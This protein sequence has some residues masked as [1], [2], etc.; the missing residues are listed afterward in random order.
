[1]NIKYWRQS[2]GKLYL[3]LV[4]LGH[5]MVRGFF[6]KI[7]INNRRRISPTAPVLLASNHPTAFV[8][9]CLLCVYIDRPIYN[10]T[11][12]DVFKQPFFRHLLEGINMFPVYR[13]RDGYSG[14]D[15][16]DEVFEFCINTLRRN[17]IVT[18]YVEGEH[19]LEKQ[20]RPVQKGIARIA[21]N[22]YEQHRME[23]LQIMPAGCNYCYGDRARDEVMVNFG[24]PIFVRDYWDDY[25]QNPAQTIQRLCSDIEKALHTICYHVDDR[26]DLPLAE[27]LLTLHR[28]DQP[29]LPIPLVAENT[30]RFDGEKAVCDA[31]NAMPTH[32]KEGLRTRVDAYFDALAKAGLDDASVAV[33]RYGHWLWGIFFGIGFPFYV[34][35]RLS[36]WPVRAAAYYVG[37]NKVKKREFFTS[38]VM[39]MGFLSGLFWYFSLFFAALFTLN[40]YW[41]GLAL[42]L[43][44]LGWFSMFYR[45]IWQRWRAGVRARKH[46]ERDKLR[47]MRKEIR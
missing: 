12:G 28:G 38:V 4:P 44:L 29:D 39:G 37:N 32:E 17:R 27:Q 24:E 42:L 5:L 13:A 40:P 26:A 8:D 19:H 31:L 23:D 43:P 14:R 6:R 45:E 10:M 33:P 35:G 2:S 34:A 16:N 30:K 22:A 20:V 7:N 46:P 36:S 3:I 47:A 25:Q 18:I 9:P 21:F 15:R 1:M 41:I 11:R